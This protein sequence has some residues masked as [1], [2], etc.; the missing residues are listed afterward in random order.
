MPGPESR[1]LGKTSSDSESQ[2]KPSLAQ[3]FLFS[4]SINTMYIHN[5][6]LKKTICF[7][8]PVKSCTQK[9]LVFDFLKFRFNIFKATKLHWSEIT[10]PI[11][12]VFSFYVFI[13]SCLLTNCFIANDIV[14]KLTF[15]PFF[16]SS[17]NGFSSGLNQVNSH[18]SNKLSMT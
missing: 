11:R 10:F 3:D 2:W 16:A 4:Q 8:D 5:Y 15:F 18:L 9:H 6:C 7:C 1:T 17:F 12:N 13:Y 14:V